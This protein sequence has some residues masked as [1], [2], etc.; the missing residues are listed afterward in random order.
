MRAASLQLQ[1]HAWPR[2]LRSGRAI[3]QHKLLARKP[4]L[5][6]VLRHGLHVMQANKLLARY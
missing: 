3:L 5:Q 6:Q 1:L 4:A 2:R